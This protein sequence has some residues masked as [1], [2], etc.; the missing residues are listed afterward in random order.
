MVDYS[1]LLRDAL[2]DLVRV[3]HLFDYLRYS[4]TGLFRVH[5]APTVPGGPPFGAPSQEPRGQT[6]PSVGTEILGSD[7]SI[8][9]AGSL[10]QT[11]PS[12]GTGSLGP[13]F[14]LRR[15]RTLGV[16]LPPPSGQSPWA[17]TYPSIETGPLGT[18]LPPP[19][20]QGP[21]DQTSPSTAT[22]SLEVVFTLRR[23]RVL[24]T[25]FRPPSRQDPW[26]DFPLPRDGR[27]WGSSSPC[28]ET[29]LL[30]SDSS[31]Y[32]G[33]GISEPETPTTLGVRLPQP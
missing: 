4:S 23:D 5:S 16:R 32:V 31:F 6:T 10:D 24:G 14:F 21:W 25:R 20:R 29:G 27:P 9:R 30:E 17:Q 33:M 8:P 15:D 22:G 12:I 3:V 11:S 2:R 19:S 7:S 26:V 28:T 13:N 1:C 18:R